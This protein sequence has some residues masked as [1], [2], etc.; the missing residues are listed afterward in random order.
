MADDQSCGR[1]FLMPDTLGI[2]RPVH[3]RFFHRFW[4]SSA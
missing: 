4:V 1:A 2:S 3:E